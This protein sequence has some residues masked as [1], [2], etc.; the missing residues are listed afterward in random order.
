MAVFRGARLSSRETMAT[1]SNRQYSMKGTMD[2]RSTTRVV[3]SR[4]PRIVA[5]AL[6]A[7]SMVLAGPS[8][9]AR[10]DDGSIKDRSS[11]RASSSVKLKIEP[12]STGVIQV[13]AVVWSDDSD[14]WSWKMKHNDDVSAKGEV[15]AKDADKSFK[16]VR[17]MADFS[18][19]DYV[20]FR[21]QN[22]ATGEICKNELTY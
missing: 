17:D 4:A 19:P 14:T 12:E 7:A 3:H 18:G 11:C 2:H 6:L 16:I 8:A 5:A 20:E 15:K 1:D 13:T 9:S 21:A 22:E 10:K